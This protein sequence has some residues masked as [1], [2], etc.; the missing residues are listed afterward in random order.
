MCVKRASHRPVAGGETRCGADLASRLRAKGTD[1]PVSQN[2]RAADQR[3]WKFRAETAAIF[4]PT[5]GRRRA[6]TPSPG[7]RSRSAISRKCR[8]S[9]SSASKGGSI[10]QNDWWTNAKCKWNTCCLRV[11]VHFRHRSP[12]SEFVATRRYPASRTRLENRRD[13]DQRAPDFATENWVENHPIGARRD[14]LRDARPTRKRPDFLRSFPEKLRKNR[15]L[16][17]R[18]WVM[19]D[20]NL[21]PAD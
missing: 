2:R 8:R 17:T 14:C 13:A 5:V 4:Q 15:Y 16:R 7:P 21:R 12:G 3:V 1:E 19:Q 11:T 20:S 10:V 6:C 18:W 9:S